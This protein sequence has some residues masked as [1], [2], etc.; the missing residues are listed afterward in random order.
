MARKRSRS[1]PLMLLWSK[2]EQR[3]F[4]DSVERLVSTVNDFSAFLADQ[5]RRRRPRSPSNPALVDVVQGLLE[6]QLLPSDFF[7]RPALA[8]LVE[9]ARVALGRAPGGHA[10]SPTSSAREAN[11]L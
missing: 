11:P 9:R 8:E 10:A 5:S 1:T 3:R 6:L 4:I 2:A 7:D